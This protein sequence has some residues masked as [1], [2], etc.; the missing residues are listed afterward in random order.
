[1]QYA[2]VLLAA[3]FTFEI[4]NVGLEYYIHF[5][6]QIP[7]GLYSF[8]SDGRN[9]AVDF[10]SDFSVLTLSVTSITVIVFYKHWIQMTEME[11]QIETRR[12]TVELEN[13]RNKIGSEFLLAKLKKAAALCLT[14]PLEVSPLLLTLS[15]IVRYR[16]YD[17]S[18][19]IV[20]LNSE[21][22]I[23]K[24]YLNLEK[25]CG[26]LTDFTLSCQ[27]RTGICFIPPL[28]LLSFVKEHL[29]NSSGKERMEIEI[30]ICAG[31]L[32][33]TCTNNRNPPQMDKCIF[34]ISRR[35]ENAL[36]KTS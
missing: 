11:E 1:M 6:Y 21:I 15:R 23:L 29:F 27:M 13:L 8:F 2:A 9:K 18:D 28:T 35:P 25:K 34:T 19:P 20:P 16:L 31:T 30:E 5:K 22:K 4:S 14:E 3:I 24:D 7:F 17:C 26:A 32:V 10:F 36:H 12:L 33:C